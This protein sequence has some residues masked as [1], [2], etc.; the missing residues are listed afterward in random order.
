MDSSGPVVTIR[1]SVPEAEALAAG[2]GP[3]DPDW[4]HDYP[5]G[6]E[7]SV[8]FSAAQDIITR[9]LDG[10]IDPP[11]CLRYAGH[12]VDRA[13][14]A[15]HQMLVRSARGAHALVLGSTLHRADGSACHVARKAHPLYT[16]PGGYRGQ[17]LPVFLAGNAEAKQWLSASPRRKR[18]RL[19]W[20]QSPEVRSLPFADVQG[21]PLE[22]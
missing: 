22:T 7:L 5:D 2:A 3:D 21:I 18:C 10:E 9:T 6:P 20:P 16:A 14:V 13:E 12:L 19:C 17:R 8:A 4:H 15:F 11:D 1:L